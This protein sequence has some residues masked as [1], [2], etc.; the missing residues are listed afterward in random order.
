MTAETESVW[1]KHS[2]VE[3]NR[4][5]DVCPV[6]GDTFGRAELIQDDGMPGRKHWHT[7]LVDVEESC[8]EWSTGETELVRD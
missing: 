3:I 5:A 1:Q 7:D 6:C 8:I 2:N 4:E